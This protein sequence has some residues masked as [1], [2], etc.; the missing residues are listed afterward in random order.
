M[1][2]AFHLHV[3]KLLFQEENEQKKMKSNHQPAFTA[4]IYNVLTKPG[5]DMQISKAELLHDSSSRASSALI[6]LCA[7]SGAKPCRTSWLWDPAENLPEATDP[8]AKPGL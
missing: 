4:S 8:V 2:R 5:K 7:T 6:S 1:T 3:S